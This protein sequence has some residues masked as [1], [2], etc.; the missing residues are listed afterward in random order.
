M[1]YLIMCGGNYHSEP[2]TLRIVKGEP[3][4]ART[5]RLLQ[6]NGVTDIA[7]TSNDER[8]EQF[9]VPVLHHKNTFGDGGHWLEGFYPTIDPAC[10]L[11]GDVF[12]SSKAIKTIVETETDDVQFFATS[13]P[14]FHKRWAEPFGFKVA[15]QEHFQTAIQEAIYLANHGH[16]FR[17]PIAWE[18]WQ[19]IKETPLNHIIY[20]NYKSIND[21][22]CDIDSEEEYQNLKAFLE[23]IEE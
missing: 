18:L 8:F 14:S 3:L 19:V 5:I 17:E 6:E 2:K 4:V 21:Y 16:F 23:D 22:S 12:F 11:F 15:D 7:I 20:T 1:K 13:I 9:G 10:Y